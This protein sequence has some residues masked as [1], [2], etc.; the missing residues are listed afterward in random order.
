MC[1]ITGQTTG[2]IEL[3]FCVDPGW[4]RGVTG[5][6]KF[7]FPNY[8]FHFFQNSLSNFFPRATSGPLASILYKFWFVIS[9]MLSF[10]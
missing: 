4:L 2:P 1:C 7:F 8:F 3:K 9:I 6:K 5:K 10:M